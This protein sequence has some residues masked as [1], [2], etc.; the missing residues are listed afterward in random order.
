MSNDKVT[1][2]ASV[3]GREAASAGT[4][5]DV[6]VARVD[7]QSRQDRT[8][9]EQAKP[10]FETVKAVAAQLDAY[11]KSVSRALEFRV[12][13]ASGHTVVSVRDAQTGELIRQIP[14]EEVLR[15]AEM[16]HDETLVLVNETV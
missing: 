5:K 7:R 8:Q 4:R 15:L 11:L 3:T 13:A 6:A 1:L 16:A 2:I 10:S 14:N 12:D 9:S